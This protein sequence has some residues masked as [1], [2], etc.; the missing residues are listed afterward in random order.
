M[1]KLLIIEDEPIIRAGIVFDFDW[2]SM[3]CLV[4]GD[5]GDGQEAIDKIKDLSPDIILL[6]INMPVKS[7]IDVLKETAEEYNYST[8]VISGYS[9]FE[10]AKQAIELGVISYINKPIDEN[11]LKEAIDKAKLIQ[12]EKKLIQDVIYKKDEIKN[13][14]ILNLEY[15]KLEYE[16]IVNDIL[17]FIHSNYMNKINI[18]D[19]AINLHYSETFLS[20]KFK[21]T[22]GMT[23]NEYLNKF[24][25]Q[26]AIDLIKDNPSLSTGDLSYLVGIGD[27]KYFNVVFKKFAGISFKEYVLSIAN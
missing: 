1:Y 19:I 23:I 9:S 5:S 25:I 22:M 10:Y 8:I 14:K 13:I 20:K 16:K 21:E 17:D 3:D 11:E 15:S 4:V 26:K 7:G 12:E 18:N 6:D 27:Q 24:R 2:K